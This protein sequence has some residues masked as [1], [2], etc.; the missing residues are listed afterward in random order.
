MHD[1]NI[2]N[3]MLKIVTQNRR[4]KRNKKK[5]NRKSFERTKKIINKQ[6]KEK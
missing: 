6:M 2:T 3:L 1:N 4:C 5:N